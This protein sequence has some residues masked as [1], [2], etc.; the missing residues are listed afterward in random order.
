MI[1]FR[2]VLAVAALLLTILSVWS[3]PV[4]RGAALTR[5]LAA[6]GCVVTRFR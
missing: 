6:V 4:M 2:S 3:R 5:R 1:C